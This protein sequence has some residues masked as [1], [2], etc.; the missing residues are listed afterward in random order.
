MAMT[1]LSPHQLAGPCELCSD[2]ATKYNHCA[3]C[4]QTFMTLTELSEHLEG[5]CWYKMQAQWIR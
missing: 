5:P 1:H 2:D 4:G 3:W